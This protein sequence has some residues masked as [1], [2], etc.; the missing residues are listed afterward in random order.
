MAGYSKIYC[1]GFMGADGLALPFFR[2]SG[3][4]ITNKETS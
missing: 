4:A 2:I 1:V 3:V